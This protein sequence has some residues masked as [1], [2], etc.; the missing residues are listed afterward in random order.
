VKAEDLLFYHQEA[1]CRLKSELRSEKYIDETSLLHQLVKN[2]LSLKQTKPAKVAGF[3]TRSPGTALSN[4]DKKDKQPV[5]SLDQRFH[6]K[7]NLGC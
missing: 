7:Q 4:V 2:L 3:A 6:I 1:C 5:R